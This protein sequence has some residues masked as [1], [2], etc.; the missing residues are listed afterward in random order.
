MLGRYQ[1]IGHLAAGGMAEILLG[2]L[3]GPSGFERAVVIKRVLPHLARSRTFVQMFL[4]EARMVARIR[5]PNVVH[6]HELGREGED[7]FLVLEYLEGESLGALCRRLWMRDAPLGFDLSARIVADACAGL[8]AAHEMTDADGVPQ[9]LV[10][11]DVS[12]QNVFVAY[13]GSVKLLDFGIATAADRMTRTEPGQLKGKFAYMA[14]EQCLGEPFD[15]RIDVFAL[16]VVLY[17]ISTSRRL[18]QRATEHLT[19]K[20]ICEE[21]LV[22]PSAVVA[23]YPRSLEAVCMR[24]LARRPGD[25]Y[26]T[27]AEMR[28]DLLQF[29]REHGSHMLPEEAL[30]KL[31]RSLFDDRIREKSEMLRRVKTGDTVTHLPPADVDTDVDLP[32]VEQTQAVGTTSIRRSVDERGA[33]RRFP[34]AVAL[35]AAL[36]GGGAA[37]ALRG[38]SPPDTGSNAAAIEI[39]TAVLAPTTSEPTPSSAAPPP[40]E[41]LPVHLQ[42]VPAG[43]RVVAGDHELGRTPTDVL[44]QAGST[45][46]AE[47]HLAGHAV[48][49][50]TLDP[51]AQ[52]SLSV[53]LR[54]VRAPRSSPSAR[55]AARPRATATA[56]PLKE[57]W[58]P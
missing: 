14:P 17:E 49:R 8:H 18:F 4:D 57:P 16:G 19:L 26:P 52:P 20:A 1:I 30:A 34:L 58:S 15:R 3:V 53:V 11:R 56:D 29:L 54:R 12:P 43:A 6:V 33:R 37:V 41:Q 2:R 42:T 32:T 7:L 27:A 39:G 22:P 28:R 13:D 36:L 51:R 55:P 23:D 44:V 40:P 46:D 21:P 38:L 5:H 25:R 45:L 35:G 10:H 9:H 50:V 47:L 31:M 24:A 48:E